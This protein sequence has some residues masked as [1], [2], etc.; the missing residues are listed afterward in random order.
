MRKNLKKLIIAPLFLSLLTGCDLFSTKNSSG[1]NG[2]S[3]SGSQETTTS[4]TNSKGT[5]VSSSASQSTVPFVDPDTPYKGTYADFWAL[6]DVMKVSFSFTN[7]SLYALS[8]YGAKDSEK[9]GDVYFPADMTIEIAGATYKY[10][11]VGVRMK[12]NTSRTEFLNSDGSFMDGKYA[13][14]KVSFKATFDDTAY[15]SLDQFKAFAHDWTNAADARK[16]RKSRTLALMEKIDFKVL[17]RNTSTYSQEMYC[18]KAFN[19]NGISAPYTHWSSLT[20]QDKKA[21]R[22]SYYEMVEDIDKQFLKNRFGKDEA[23]G[24][25]YKCVWGFPKDTNNWKGADL[26]RSEAITD[27]KD[28][29]GYSA[30][31]RIAY[32]RIGVEDNFNNYHP[33]YQLKTNDDG[34]NSDFSKLVHYINVVHSCRYE[35]GTQAMLEGVLDVQE[36][37]KFEALSYLFGNFDDQ[38]NNYNNYFLY[39]RPSDGKAIYIPYDWDWSLGNDSTGK[40]QSKTP[41]DATDMNGNAVANNLYYETIL[42]DSSV[43]FSIDTYKANYKSYIQAAITAGVLDKANYSFF[44]SS[45]NHPE[46]DTVSTYMDAKKTVALQ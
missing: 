9:W 42:S 18:Y 32:G 43:K 44:V 36:F 28:S 17:P 1:T 24:D 27:V 40:M 30:G 2:A 19:D 35:N 15:Y 21:T 10:Y 4:S 8:Y 34:E 38:R 14:F 46:L 29:S 41:F 33:N 13:H 39:F 22:T 12:G 31:T 45:Y 11:E 26:S 7:E 5:S 3:S 25:L 20:L 16:A 6:K 37:L 23:Q